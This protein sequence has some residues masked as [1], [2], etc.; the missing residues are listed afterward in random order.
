MLCADVV[1]HSV[2]VA[3][4]S[5]T[6]SFAAPPSHACLTMQGADLVFITAGMG[7]GTGT[8]AAPVV[9][10][11]SKEMGEQATGQGLRGWWTGGLGTGC[12]QLAAA[13][14]LP[15]QEVCVPRDLPSQ[16]TLT[17]CHRHPDGGCCHVPVQF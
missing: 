3:R 17:L 8:G 1:G 4:P 11:L 2:C 16:V 5:L 13:S 6:L 14:G 12:G 15:Q 9:A 7:G 10:R